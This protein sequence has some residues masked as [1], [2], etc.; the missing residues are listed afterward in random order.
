[1]DQCVTVLTYT[2]L[3]GTLPISNQN[4]HNYFETNNAFDNDYDYDY[5]NNS[6]EIPIFLYFSLWTVAMG[7]A[8]YNYYDINNRCY[9]LIGKTLNKCNDCIKNI[10]PV[11]KKSKYPSYPYIQELKNMN[12]SIKLTKSDEDYINDKTDIDKTDIDKTDIEKT[13][14]EN[15]YNQNENTT[16]DNNQVS[17]Y[18]VILNNSF[19]MDNSVKMDKVDKVDRNDVISSILNQIIE[20]GRHLNISVTGLMLCLN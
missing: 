3:Y 10:F 16:I 14:I 13:D 19:K 15:K 5:D 18:S 9:S 17:D 12:S 2:T 4:I 20:K 11:F 8:T 1:M 7:I 6:S